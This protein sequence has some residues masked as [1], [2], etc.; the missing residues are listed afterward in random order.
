MNF[1][2]FLKVLHDVHVP[3]LNMS[4]NLAENE[5]KVTGTI[6]RPII[7][8]EIEECDDM[9]CLSQVEWTVKLCQEINLGI[10]VK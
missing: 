6:E 8:E 5:E 3:L 10:G 4:E 2:K 7:I 9:K 1:S